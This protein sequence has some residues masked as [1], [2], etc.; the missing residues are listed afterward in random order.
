MDRAAHGNDPLAGAI[1]AEQLRAIHQN[2]PLVLI[3]NVVIP[4]LTVWALWDDID[5]TLALGWLMLMLLVVALR[6]AGWIAYRRATTQS[7]AQARRW[8]LW[9]IGSAFASGC[10]WGTAGVMLNV[11][12]SPLPFSLIILILA[13]MGAAAVISYAAILPVFY[14]YFLPSLVPFVV[15]AL[16]GPAQIQFVMAIAATIFIV[17][18]SILARTMHRMLLQSLR[19]RFENLDL[20]AELRAQKETAEQANAAKTRFLAAASHDLRQP[21]HAMGLFVSALAERVRGAAT[22]KLVTQLIA[23][24]EALRS[25]LD[26]LL[27]ISRLD[28]SVIHP[29][30]G[31]VPLQDLFDRLAHDYAAVSAEKGL[32][33]RFMPTRLTVR[34]DPPLVERIMRNLVANAVR[35]TDRG[36]IVVGARRHRTGV[37][38]EVWDTGIGIAANERERIFHEFYQVGNPERDRGKGLGLG[39]AI[40]QR[41]AHLLG[42]HIEV[43]STPGHGSHFALT[44]P[45]GGKSGTA[46]SAAPVMMPGRLPAALIVVIDDEHTVLQATQ[47][48]LEGWGCETVLADSGAAAQAALAERGR[49][50]QLIIADYRLRDGETGAGAIGALQAEHGADIPAILVTGDTAPERLREAQASGYHL[51]AK[52]LAPAQL[53]A[54]VRYLLVERRSMS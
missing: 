16:F 27:D 18:V 39:L 33:L 35:Y 49:R 24:T 40:A 46:P 32:R 19:L 20:V 30:I 38:L 53:R 7:A 14:A 12:D 17:A 54:L 31:D 13:G 52:P 47:A 22:R 10:L 28:A 41:L 5:H 51:L 6:A 8:S 25:L 45:R 15:T 37:R 4:L 2:L 34:G 48:L 29:R 21:L 26:G 43:G 42:S 23:S 11:P 36:G 3:S 1:R 50:P 9:L 44:L